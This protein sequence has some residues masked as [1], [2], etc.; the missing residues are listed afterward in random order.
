[1]AAK[2]TMRVLLLVVLTGLLLCPGAVASIP[3]ACD[4]YSRLPGCPRD[5][6]PVCGTDGKTYPNECVLCL[7][8][9]E[10]NKNVQ[11]YKSGMC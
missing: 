5:Y 1:M 7:S 6:S 3:P 10:E 8:N 9:S 11:I 2:L 4:K